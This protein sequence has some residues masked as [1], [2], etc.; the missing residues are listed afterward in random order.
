[1]VQANP[2]G[3][4]VATGQGTLLLREVQPAGKRR[5][6]AQEFLAGYRVAVG[7]RFGV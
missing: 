4:L 5:M 7:A 3:L 6:S 2:E 1:V